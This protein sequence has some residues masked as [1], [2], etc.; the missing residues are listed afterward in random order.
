MIFIDHSI[1]LR[2]IAEKNY[3]CTSNFNVLVIEKKTILRIMM[4]ANIYN[5]KKSFSMRNFIDV[6]PFDFWVKYDLHR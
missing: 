3:H 4:H 1:Y 6:F 5:A 2:P